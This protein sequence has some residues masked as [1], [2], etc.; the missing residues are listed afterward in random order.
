MKI[1]KE[2]QRLKKIL[3]EVEIKKEKEIIYDFDFTFK[4]LIS[5]VPGVG[6]RTF[7]KN[8]TREIFESIPIYKETY[9]NYRIIKEINSTNTANKIVDDINKVYK[10]ITENYRNLTVMLDSN[11]GFHINIDSGIELLKFDFKSDWSQ[12]MCKNSLNTQ[13][14]KNFV[15]THTSSIDIIEIFRKYGFQV[16]ILDDTHYYETKNLDLLVGK[17]KEISRLENVGLGY[18]TKSFVFDNTTNIKIQI[19]HSTLEDLSVLLPN[20]NTLD[21][22]SLEEFMR[23]IR[24]KLRITTRESSTYNLKTI[25]NMYKGSKGAIIM[26]DITNSNSLKYIHELIRTIRENAGD[27][28]I[29]LVGNKVDMEHNREVLQ[30]EVIRFANQYNIYDVIEISAKEGN[31]CESV[32][33]KLTMNFIKKEHK[34]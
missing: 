34:I 5:G 12:F 25:K 19:W 7:L 13:P 24:E 2:R 18:Y 16:E 23:T 30:E 3:G 22:K 9:I 21:I 20:S 31:N 26:Y 14:A 33:E 4:I 32:F 1:K 29:L 17:N 15:N 11:I 27:I 6:I 28:P 8:H 10:E